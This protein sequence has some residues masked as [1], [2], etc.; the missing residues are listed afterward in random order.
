MQQP[1]PIAETEALLARLSMR[2]GVQSTL[3]LSRQSGAIVRSSGLITA[4]ELAQ[5]EVAPSTT[6]GT[7]VNSTDGEAVRKQGTRNAEE[8]AQSV[9][10][11][12][13]SVGSMIEELNGDHDEAKLLRIRTK[14]NEIVVVPDA[15][16]LL[17]CIH[18]TPPA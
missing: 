15:K 9:W 13:K 2:P 1:S 14:R 18:D 7:Y 5:E 4:E 11:F 17:V 6:N 16:F 8:V 12:M 3:I 10:T